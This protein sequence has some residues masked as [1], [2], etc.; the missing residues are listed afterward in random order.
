[1]KSKFVLTKKSMQE[2][3]SVQKE[4]FAE[5]SL[6][7][8]IIEHCAKRLTNRE[9]IE[10]YKDL[11]CQLAN[12]NKDDIPLIFQEMFKEFEVAMQNRGIKI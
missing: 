11:S 1:M 2:L 4:G 3:I 7:S 10:V 12:M 5:L 6:W 9:M 8:G